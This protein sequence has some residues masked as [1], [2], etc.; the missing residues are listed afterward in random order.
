MRETKGGRTDKVVLFSGPDLE[1]WMLKVLCGVLVSGNASLGGEKAVFTLP[2]DWLEVLMGRRPMQARRGLG[3]ASRV[4]D[5][6]PLMTASDSRRFTA[7]EIVPWARSCR[8][9]GSFSA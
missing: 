6:F 4:G 8:S 5:D 7:T 2:S 9:T 1:R 3:V